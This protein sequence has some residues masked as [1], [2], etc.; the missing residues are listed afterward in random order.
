MKLSTDIVHAMGQQI[1]RSLNPYAQ[2]IGEYDKQVNTWKAV[3]G[4][5]LTSDEVETL[6]Q[7]CIAA[8]TRSLAPNRQRTLDNMDRVRQM[9]M[10]GDSYK[11][12]LAWVEAY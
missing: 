5:V 11:Q 7:A 6:Y 4:L 2:I 3:M 1:L 9:I 12:A 8:A 10:L